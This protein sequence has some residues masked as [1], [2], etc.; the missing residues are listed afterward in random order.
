MKTEYVI[1]N[2]KP[3]KS[4]RCKTCRRNK[5]LQSIATYANKGD[6]H[7]TISHDSYCPCCDVEYKGWWIWKKAITTI[8]RE[9]VK[10]LLGKTDASGTMNNIIGKYKQVMG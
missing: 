5:I 1:V 8:H 7:L 6:T 2:E 4:G 3:R 9:T 10:Q